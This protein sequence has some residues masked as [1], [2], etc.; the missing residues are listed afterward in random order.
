MPSWA[1]GMRGLW[2]PRLKTLTPP[3]A[4]LRTPNGHIL[5]LPPRRVSIGTSP[6]NEIPI[7]AGLGLAPVHFQLQPWESGYFLEDGG[8]GLGTLV[9][10]KPVSWV[11]LNHGD[12]ISAGNLTMTY[13]TAEETETVEPPVPPPVP[14]VEATV[15]VEA[16]LTPPSTP[17]AL[18]DPAADEPAPP[19][20]SWLPPEALRP[21]VPP[22]ARPITRTAPASGNMGR[23][24][25]LVAGAGLL[26]AAGAWYYFRR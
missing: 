13:Q 15:P 16:V 26:I 23:I 22:W 12:V 4:R 3:M 18:S 6:A 7:A 24:L 14:V 5:T 10:G 1:R 2:R 17:P 21:P 11:P 8:S 9:N 20:P 19:P 25:M